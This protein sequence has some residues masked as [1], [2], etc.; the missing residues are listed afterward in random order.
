MQINQLMVVLDQ[1][2]RIVEVQ[3]GKFIKYTRFFLLTASLQRSQLTFSK[4]CE[5]N[6]KGED[7]S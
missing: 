5:K 6:V 1:S 4:S 3:F 7:T 2:P